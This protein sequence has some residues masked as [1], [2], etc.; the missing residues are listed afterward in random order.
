M[1]IIL[2]AIVLLIVQSS[3]G[4]ETVVYKNVDSTE[5]RMMVY[6]PAHMD[7]TKSYCAIVFFFGGGW[8]KGQPSQF[9]QQ[10]RYFAQKGFVCFLPNYRV[11]QRNHTTPFEALKDAKSAIRFIKENAAN[12]HVDS[13]RIIASGGSAGGHLA[14]ATALID[15]FN[16]STDNLTISS[17]P[18]ALVLFNPVIDT[19]P[20][21]NSYD[22]I[23]GHYPQFSPLHNIR[24][25]APPT[26]IMLGTKDQHI[27]V[28]TARYYQQTMEKVG[29]R[30]DL[31]LYDNAPHGFFNYSDKKE[32]PYYLKTV[33]A[34]EQFLQS[35]G[36]LR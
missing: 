27:P 11:E 28:L 34:A 4:Q 10:A 24:P 7:K 21:G 23:A 1:R 2:A 19:G 35:L 22:R 25:G 3:L 15:G 8:R 26:L 33:R 32:N 30:C 36:Y 17:K 18:Q 13:A 16:E 6:T 5:L 14:A 20:G 12:F 29:S 31:V 9:Q